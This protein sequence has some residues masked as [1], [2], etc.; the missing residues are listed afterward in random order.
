MARRRPSLLS[1][2]AY[3]RRGAMYKGVLGGSRGWLA[4]GAL[5]WGPRLVK[6]AIGK[7][8]EIV[9][10]E[11]MRPGDVLRLETIPQQTRKQRRAATRTDG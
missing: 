1:P 11:V 5:V 4:V 3:L 8:E 2:T 7:N 9:T 6:K 10:T